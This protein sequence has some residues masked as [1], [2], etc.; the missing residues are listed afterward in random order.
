MPKIRKIAAAPNAYHSPLLI[1]N[2]LAYSTMLEP[3]REI[4]YRDISRYNYWEFGK[5]I[6]RM[7]NMLMGLGIDG[8]ATIGAIDY[9]SHRYLEYYF[10]IP[11]TGNVLHTIN[12][13][14]SPAQILY[15]INHAKDTVLIV[16]EDFL[17]L[18]S[19]FE[20]QMPTVEHIIITGDRADATDEIAWY[21]HYEALLRNVSS[22]HSF[23][24]FDEDAIATVFY[25]TG[26]TGDPK[27]V[28]YSH[29]QLVLHTFHL[30][31]TFG[32]VGG[33]ACR[34]NS[35]DVYMPLTSMFHVHAWGFPYLATMFSMK[36]VYAGRFDAEIVLGLVRK[37]RP[38][39]SHC[40]ATVL[41]LL[42]NKE[43]EMPTDLSGW[44]IVGGGMPMP[45]ALCKAALAKGI[46]LV[47]S[48]GMSETGPVICSVYMP[49]S[50]AGDS[51][52]AEIAART[53]TGI[54]P[55]MVEMKVVDE[56]GR[57]VPKDDKTRGEIV[58]RAPV[59]TQGYLDDEE[60]GNELWRGGYLHTGDI[61]TINERGSIRIADR[62]KDVIKSGGE[63][64][65]G[66]ELENMIGQ[67][68]A[69]WE[70]AVV[71]VPDPK[72]GERPYALVVPRPGMHCT[73]AD[74][75]A[76]L[77][78]FV[79]SGQLSSWAMPEYFE[80]VTEIPRTS[81]GKIDKKVI[82]AALGRS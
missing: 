4:V 19:G 42:L 57:E 23:A 69:V 3:E 5:R 52:E 37:E 20:G 22:E 44:K 63:W 73:A 77:Q 47:M 31:A 67:H 39:F 76:H 10:A 9:D 26:T 15:T 49:Q 11:M 27:G 71:G 55:I 78:Q 14:L 48:Y 43:A 50:S 80:F 64:I 7:A 36:Q 72:W 25:T 16:N 38:T 70:T 2:I 1:K 13:R 75:R 30:A 33:R 56:Q 54:P 59:L 53:R 51:L 21:P 46:D 18:L 6:A 41:Q 17:P 8:G 81:V 35:D 45:R 29:R 79:T 68:A 65:P 60:R 40:V 82:R 28:F 66:I 32:F 12:W 24:D 61:A 74:L 58:V 62:L 34:A